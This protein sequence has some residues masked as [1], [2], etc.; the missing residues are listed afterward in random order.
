M[1]D[2]APEIF[3]NS[4]RGEPRLLEDIGRRMAAGL[5][6]WVEDNQIHLNGSRSLVDDEL[7]VQSF[8]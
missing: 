1:T 5:S 4:A 2:S 8:A 3:D 7:H 6:L